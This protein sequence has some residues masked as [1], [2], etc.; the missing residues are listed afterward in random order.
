MIVNAAQ[1][2]TRKP[3][4]AE[5][6]AD[7][8]NDMLLTYSP[9]PDAIVAFAQERGVISGIWVEVTSPLLIAAENGWTIRYDGARFTVAS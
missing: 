2:G 8:V 9:N 7:D 3:R 5:E 6:W 1:T 4:T